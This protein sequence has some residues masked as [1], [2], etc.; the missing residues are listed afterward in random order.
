MSWLIC[1]R[2]QVSLH[3]DA[4]ATC[5]P[6]GTSH[7]STSVSLGEGG[8]RRGLGHIAFTKSVPWMSRDHTGLGPVQG[9]RGPP[10]VIPW[11]GGDCTFLRVCE[12][13]TVA[14]PSTRTAKA[15][16]PGLAPILLTAVLAPSSKLPLEA[17]S[18]RPQRRGRAGRGKELS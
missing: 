15:Q 3:R 16:R 14:F 6:A 9:T 2:R 7:A 8:Q 12:M 1:E 4:A 11:E 18:W 17:C 13:P 10:P 5:F